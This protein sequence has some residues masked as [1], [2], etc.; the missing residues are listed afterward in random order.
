MVNKFVDKNPFVIR[1]PRH[2][3]GAFHLHR[4]IQKDDY[5]EGQENGKDK[6]A[7]PIARVKEASS[8]VCGR[9]GHRCYF[10][11]GL[12]VAQF[13]LLPYYFYTTSLRIP[14]RIVDG[15]VE[16]GPRDRPLTVSGRAPISLA[17]RETGALPNTFFPAGGG[18]KLPRR[19]L[20]TATDKQAWLNDSRKETS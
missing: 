3:T 19:C 7:Q 9:E 20:A 8:G 4:L 2:H 5:D 17:P 13:N 12:N 18:G 1:K 11:M 10:G 6:V 14:S 16:S 15:H